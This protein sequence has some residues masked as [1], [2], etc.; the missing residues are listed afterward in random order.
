MSKPKKLSCGVLVVDDNNCLLMQHVR[1]PDHWDIPKGGQKN[2]ETT[3]ATAIRE[4]AEETGVIADEN[5]LIDIGIFD[6]NPFKDIYLFVLRV[7]NI[8][9]R[10]LTVNEA[11]EGRD[12]GFVDEYRMIPW[13]ESS[14]FMCQSLEYLFLDR[15][16]REV[17][18]VINRF[19]NNEESVSI[20]YIRD[21]K[22]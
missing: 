10:K 1:G 3:A 22:E 20:Q 19:N 15:M 5:D 7:K 16:K 4:L 13:E 6:Y 17:E 8:D 12:Y 14:G 9:I 11:K 21:K 2:W 18:I